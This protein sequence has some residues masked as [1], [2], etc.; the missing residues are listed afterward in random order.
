MK[1]ERTYHYK[2]TKDG[3]RIR[4][5]SRAEAIAFTHTTDELQQ[6]RLIAATKI[7]HGIVYTGFYHIMKV[8]PEESEGMWYSIVHGEIGRDKMYNHCRGD[9]AE[10]LKMHERTCKQAE[11]AIKRNMLKYA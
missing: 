11:K 3:N 6:E 8:A 5:C 10:A 2:L 1:R 7:E 9:K 4:K